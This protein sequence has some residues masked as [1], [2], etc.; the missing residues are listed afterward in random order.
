MLQTKTIIYVILYCSFVI[1]WN[2]FIIKRNMFKIFLELK[3]FNQKLFFFLVSL[4]EIIWFRLFKIKMLQ[5]KILVSLFVIWFRNLYFLDEQLCL[6]VAF[7]TFFF[8]IFQKNSNW[9]Q[10][11]NVKHL[12]VVRWVELKLTEVLVQLVF[13]SGPF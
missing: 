9:K 6:K 10:I 13:I 8:F 4:F 1:W 11:K 2:L 7:K 12:T 5:K 3:C